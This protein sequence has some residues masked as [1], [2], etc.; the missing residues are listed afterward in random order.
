M[1]ATELGFA[2]CL[3]LVKMFEKSATR[4]QKWWREIYILFKHAQR[5]Q[6][7]ARGLITRR[8]DPRARMISKCRWHNQNSVKVTDTFECPLCLHVPTNPV[9]CTVDCRI[10]EH[11]FIVRWITTQA[12]PTSPITRQRITMMDLYTLRGRQ[13]GVTPQTTLEPIDLTGGL[14]GG[15]SSGSSSFGTSLPFGRTGGN[16][17]E[18]NFVFGR[19]NTQRPIRLTEGIPDNLTD[20]PGSLINAMA[21]SRGNQERPRPPTGR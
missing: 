8:N 11:D 1:Q 18:N 19:T 5:I 4:I 12:N 15:D 16:S 3:F 13:L 17:S 21:L 2:Q 6:K 7:I 14:T 20:Q 10:Y 9:F